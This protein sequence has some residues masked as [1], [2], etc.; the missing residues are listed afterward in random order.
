MKAI[1]GILKDTVSS[2]IADDA[3]T[4]AAAL[5]LYVT[6]SLAPIMLLIIY[7]GSLLGPDVQ[8]RMVD[9]MTSMVGEQA[10]GILTSI[11][12]NAKSQQSSGVVSAIISVTFFVFSATGV[13]GQLQYSLNRIWNVQA[14]PGQALKQ[15][16][17]KRFVSLLLILGAALILLASVVLTATLNVILENENGAFWKWMNLGASMLIYLLIFALIFKVLPDVEMRWKYVW[18]GALLTAVLFQMGKWAIALYISHSSTASVYGAAGTL[19]VFLLWLY[20]AS[21]IV[22]FGAELT[23]IYARRSGSA[24]RPSANAIALE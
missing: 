21:V 2:F 18:V 22:F 12:Q 17:R 19:L 20:Y 9:Q 8:Q 10:S 16:F 1:F 23:Q 4:L 24:I 13:V 11:L 6:I 5:T 3:M 15:W 14:K 7:V